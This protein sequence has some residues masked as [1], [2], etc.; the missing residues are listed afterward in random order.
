LIGGA[1]ALITRAKDLRTANAS[2]FSVETTAACVCDFSLD[3]GALNGPEQRNKNI[4]VFFPLQLDF[5]TN[6]DII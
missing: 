4:F 3:T 2:R 1:N 6:R 5:L